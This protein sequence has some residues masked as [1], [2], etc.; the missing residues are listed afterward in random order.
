MEQKKVIAKLNWFYSLELN[1]VDLYIAESKKTDDIYIKNTLKRVSVI[2]QQHVD[3]IASKIKKLGEKPTFLGDVIAPITGK[4][5]GNIIGLTGVINMLKINIKLE[6]KAM[7]DYKD[8][9]LKSGKD[10]DLFELL[11]SNLIDE[12]LHSAW[13]TNKI[14]E[15]EEIKS[16]Q[17][18]KLF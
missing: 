18:Q 10:K 12:D 11:W 4:I 16:K 6:E 2:E 15:L 13:F 8:F 5:G 3:N 7:L 14:Q 9:I 17:K 1:Q